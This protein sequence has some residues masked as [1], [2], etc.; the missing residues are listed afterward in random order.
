MISVAVTISVDA[1]DVYLVAQHLAA[2]GMAVERIDPTRG[3]IGGWCRQD[4][5]PKLR[6]V[7]GVATVETPA[8]SGW[9]LR[10]PM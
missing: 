2:A 10:Q 1:T 7:R 8:R 3:M 5:L 4:V 6:S 9:C